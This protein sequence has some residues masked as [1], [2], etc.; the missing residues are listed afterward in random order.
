MT[1]C[2]KLHDHIRLY[3]LESLCTLLALKKQGATL[4][5]FKLYG[6]GSSFQKL[7]GVSR[8]QPG[9]N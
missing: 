5:N 8:Q 3:Y 6:N 7:R 1:D 9:S 4:R 2:I